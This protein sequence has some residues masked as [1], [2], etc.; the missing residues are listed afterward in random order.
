MPGACGA[1]FLSLL[2]AL[3]SLLRASKQAPIVSLLLEHQPDAATEKFT[4]QA[5]GRFGLAPRARRFHLCK[6]GGP[7]DGIFRALLAQG[8]KGKQQEWWAI[9]EAEDGSTPFSVASL[10]TQLLLRPRCQEVWPG[11][12]GFS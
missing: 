4:Q 11:D 5:L 8:S 10:P 3:K 6:L 9:S 1:S 12:P 7:R 2:R